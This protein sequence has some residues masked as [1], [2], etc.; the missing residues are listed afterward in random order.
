MRLKRALRDE[1]GLNIDRSSDPQSELG[2]TQARTGIEQGL[3]ISAFPPGVI[4]YRMPKSEVRARRGKGNL[5]DDISREVEAMRE[6]VKWQGEEN[7]TRDATITELRA[8]IVE[9]RSRH[10]EL[11]AVM[12]ARLSEAE[13]K[14]SM[15][16]AVID[17]EVPPVTFAE[18]LEEFG[19]GS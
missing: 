16:R 11:L 14:M 7:R 13:G 1:R 15:V 8:M 6:H 5:L 9:E 17:G 10:D 18:V 2:T 12:E 4:P 3:N 19:I